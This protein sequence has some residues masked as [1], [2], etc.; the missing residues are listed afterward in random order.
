MLPKPFDSSSRTV[1]SERSERSTRKLF[2]W[3]HRKQK[4]RS[5]QNAGI[6]P[7]AV[8]RKGQEEWN[9][10]IASETDMSLAGLRMD[11]GTG[12]VVFNVGAG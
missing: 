5:V 2:G 12:L 4:E 8:P 3:L 10:G 11:S 9:K 6:S 7:E 1:F